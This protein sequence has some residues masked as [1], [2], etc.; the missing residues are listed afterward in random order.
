MDKLIQRS[1]E[2]FEARLG[3]VTASRIS[4][5][6]AQTKSGYGASRARYMGELI[7]ETMTKTPTA[8]Y[9]N[10]AM[11]WGLETE[12]EAADAY[13]F[14]TDAELELVG[15]V[16]HPSIDQAGCSPDRLVSAAGKNGVE[17]GL[18]E[19]KCPQTHTHID[20]LL[21]GSIPKKYIDQMQWQMAC[22]KREWCDFVSF[23]PRMPP[24]SQ[25]F[26][27]RVE[28]DEERSKELENMVVKFLFEMN[29]KIDRLKELENAA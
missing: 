6:V 14:I 21:G 20:T 2:W 24:A 9:S 4:D 27:K 29:E 3:K 12:P 16:D 15:F 11:Q 5:V 23:D 25:L 7:A 1:D 26:I 13:A 28:H 17:N 18:V 19:I 22:T 10:S 8:S